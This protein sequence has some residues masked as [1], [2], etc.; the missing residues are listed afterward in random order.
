MPYPL[1]EDS[2]KITEK[3]KWVSGYKGLYRVSSFGTV[4]SIDRIVTRSDGMIQSLKG[5]ILKPGKNDCYGYLKVELWKNGKG[6]RFYIHRLVLIAFVGH[7]PTGLE[8][9]HLDGNPTNNRIGN[10]KWGTPKEN[11]QDRIRHGTDNRGERSGNAKLTWKKVRKIRKLYSTGSISRTE[12]SLRFRV[13]YASI[14]Y[15][16][17]NKQWIE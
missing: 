7:C 11:Q 16:V 8:C 4:R 14:N 6:Q 17:Q 2:M 5:R 15:I 13:H 10:L 3:W 12:L 1:F 9:R